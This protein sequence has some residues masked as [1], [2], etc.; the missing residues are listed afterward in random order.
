MRS[1]DKFDPFFATLLSMHGNRC[2]HCKTLAPEWSKAA[3]AL[4]AK[5]SPITLAKVDATA[6]KA[7]AEKYKVSQPSSFVFFQMSCVIVYFFLVKTCIVFHCSHLIAFDC[8]LSFVV[9][10]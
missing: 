4:K 3:K 9:V 8:L 7:S 1:T 10:Y 6:A 2:G 5:N